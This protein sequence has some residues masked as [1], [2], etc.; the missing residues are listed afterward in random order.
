MLFLS[1]LQNEDMEHT[2]GWAAFYTPGLL[3][4]YAAKIGS[5]S[6]IIA[7]NILKSSL[8]ILI[9]SHN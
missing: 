6:T 7:S 4:K 9:F 2:I 8:F 3:L 5:F 1:W